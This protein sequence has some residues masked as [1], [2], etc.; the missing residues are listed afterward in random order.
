M[1]KLKE[2]KSVHPTSY[3]YD[4]LRKI[5]MKVL[6]CSTH[7][8]YLIVVYFNGVLISNGF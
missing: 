8:Q 1:A 6:V 7:I 2:N 5:L 4:F 3:F